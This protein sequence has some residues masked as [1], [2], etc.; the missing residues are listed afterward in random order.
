M[1]CIQIPVCFVSGSFVTAVPLLPLFL[2]T[3]LRVREISQY[4]H[5][6]TYACHIKILPCGQ[7]WTLIPA[8]KVTLHHMLLQASLNHQT[9]VEMTRRMKPLQYCPDPGLLLHLSVLLTMGS[10]LTLLAHMPHRHP[11]NNSATTNGLSCCL[12]CV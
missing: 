3:Y 10:L 7:S 4:F 11:E 12:L 8:L 2:T 6:S 5:R 1:N 9:H